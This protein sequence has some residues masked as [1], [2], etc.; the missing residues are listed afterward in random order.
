[1]QYGQVAIESDLQ[2]PS[3][4]AGEE[5]TEPLRDV[6]AGEKREKKVKETKKTK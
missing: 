5:P 3:E 1:M 6:V 4:D 2:D